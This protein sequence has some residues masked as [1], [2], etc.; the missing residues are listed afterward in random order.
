MKYWTLFL[1]VCIVAVV[2]CNGQ[3]DAETAVSAPTK[4]ATRP[5]IDEPTNPPTTTEAKATA[6][7]LPDSTTSQEP[8]TNEPETITILYTN[9]EHGWM[10]GMAPGT[11]A[12]ELLGIWQE[13]EGYSPDDE[14]FIILSGGDMWT[15]PAISTWF[16]GES[17]SEVMNKMGY[18]AATVGNH[19]FDFGLDMLQVRQSQSDFPILSANMRYAENNELP[20]DL[21]ILPYV[22]L[23]V[24]GIEVGIIGLTTV[25]TPRTTNP[26]NVVDFIFIDYE[27]ALREIVPQAQ[28]EGADIILVPGHI[29]QHELEGLATAVSDLNIHLFGGGHC[30]ELFAKEKNGAVLLEGGNHFRSYA[31][32]VFEVNPEDGTVEIIEVGTVQNEGGTAVSEIQDIIDKWSNVVD[33]ELNEV[34]GYTNVSI[35]RRSPEMQALITN[36]WLAGYPAADVAITNLG[37]MR[38]PIEA[39]EITLADIVTVMP[40]DNV[41]MEISLS[42]NQLLSVLDIARDDAIAG[43]HRQNFEWVLDSSGD[44][45]DP[46]ASYSLLVNDFMYAGGDEYAILAESDPNAYNTAID[47]RQPVIDWIINHESTETNS[48]DDVL[49]GLLD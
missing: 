6:L 16:D 2:G 36:A 3:T 20:T 49:A 7:P 41:I 17:M 34:I 30:N 11:G 40:F 37:G 23:P 15:G 10:E 8:A 31:R 47:W 5:A 14:S 46:D 19:E 27:T 12:A 22:I 4:T 43:V 38:A 21:G 26:N 9:D 25:S 39:G 45:I 28:A 29:C 44:S 13:V 1:L 32:A 42:G 33:A 18:D 24:D 35:E 48:I